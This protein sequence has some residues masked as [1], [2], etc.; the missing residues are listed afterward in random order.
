ML[1]GNKIRQKEDRRRIGRR[2][3]RRRLFL[4]LTQGALARLLGVTFQQVQK[5]ENGANRVPPGRLGQ[6]AH[7]LEVTPDYFSSRDAEQ[8]DAVEHFVQSPDGIALYRA[9]AL[10]GDAQIRARLVLAIAAL[11]DSLARPEENDSGPISRWLRLIASQADQDRHDK[12]IRAAIHALKVELAQLIGKTLK[13]RKLTQKFAARILATDQARISALASGNV[14][15][16]SFEKLL[17]YLVL[18]GWQARIA[19]A[20]RPLH[21][22]GKI[23]LIS[24]SEP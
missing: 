18:L 14:D 7:Y 21:A 5:Y 15:A 11:S 6:I 4:G 20:R 17:R 3:R 10:I 1:A 9:M 24:N 23:E 16:A 2:I 12:T 8:A 22:R 19:I 13:A